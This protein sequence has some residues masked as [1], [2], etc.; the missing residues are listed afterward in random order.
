MQPTSIAP[1]QQLCYYPIP[2]PKFQNPSLHCHNHHFPKICS[3]HHPIHYQN[4]PIIKPNSNHSPLSKNTSDLYSLYST[5]SKDQELKNTNNPTSYPHQN[6][7]FLEQA[8]N[9]DQIKKTQLKQAQK[10][11]DKECLDLESR[12]LTVRNMWWDNIIAAIGQR[13]NLEGIK[14]SVGVFTKDRHLLVP[15]VAVPDIRY[16]DWGELKRRGFEGVVFDKDN[17][18][19]VPYSLSLWGPIRP[20]VEDCKSVFGSNIAVFSNSAGLH[21]Y[22]PDG[23]KAR[24][25]E[26]KIGIKVIRHKVK[27][28]AGSAEEIE[29]H[30]GCDSTRLIMVGDRAFTDI[31]YGNRNGFLTILTNPLSLAE[32]PFIVRQVRK[33]EA[34]FVK[35]WS[36]KGIKPIGHGLLSDS[37]DC[38]KDQPSQQVFFSE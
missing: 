26:F 25:L 36:E 30:F 14:C 21:E 19:T 37:R 23:R 17:T 16:I 22:D 32:E 28:P 2:I 6:H 11:V 12:V 5:C 15:H 29:K 18:L 20:S 7:V 27:K 10:V 8:C 13:I 34:A 31:V 3:Y 35:R 38:V 1:W 33:L 9:S 4:K 24:A